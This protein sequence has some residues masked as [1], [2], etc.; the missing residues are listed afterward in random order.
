VEQI[1]LKI[2][3]LED[4]QNTCSEYINKYPELKNEILDIYT[5]CL[6]EIEE[7][8]SV[9]HEISLGMTDLEELINENS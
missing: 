6:D 2:M 5:L 9:N 4:F 1:K 7:G 3:T 8:G